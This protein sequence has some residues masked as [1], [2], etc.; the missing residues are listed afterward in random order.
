MSQSRMIPAK[1]AFFLRIERSLEQLPPSAVIKTLDLQCRMLAEDVQRGRPAPASEVASIQ[2][3]YHFI[4]SVNRDQS[5]PV[6][7]WPVRLEHLKCFLNLLER[8]IRAG[9]LPPEAMTQFC[10]LYPRA[11]EEMAPINDQQPVV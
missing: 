1:S 10:R 11:C 5:Q 9:E 6:K 7:P 8:L 2:G 3:F 4:V